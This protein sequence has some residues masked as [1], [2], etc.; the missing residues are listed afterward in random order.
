MRGFLLAGV[1]PPSAGAMKRRPKKK[2][3]MKSKIL[4]LGAAVAAFTFTSFAAD[5]LLSPRAAGNKIKVVPG[6]TA[7]QPAPANVSLLTPRAADSQIKTVAGVVNDPNP[8]V[9]CRNSMN[10]T[11]KAVAECSSHTTMPACM[12]VATK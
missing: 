3:N 2:E 12:T 5:A 8:A 10:G 4:L 1:L 7:A 11:P 6:I 9:A